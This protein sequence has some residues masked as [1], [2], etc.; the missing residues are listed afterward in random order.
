[1]NTQVPAI[2][3][4][5]VMGL[6][7]H[8]GDSYKNDL[9]LKA[10]H[11]QRCSDIPTFFLT[12]HLNDGRTIDYRYVNIV[13]LIQHINDAIYKYFEKSRYEKYDYTPVGIMVVQADPIMF[14]TSGKQPETKLDKLVSVIVPK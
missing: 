9:I 1:M 12:I 14:S 3:V 10:I 2:H 4:N 13:E 5:F 11:T 7:K 6:L 8:K